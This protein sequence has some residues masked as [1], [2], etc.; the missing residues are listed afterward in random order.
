MSRTHS[1]PH[2]LIWYFTGVKGTKS[3][4]ESR[5]L[6]RREKDKQ[7]GGRKID[8]EKKL[9]NPMQH[10]ADVSVVLLHQH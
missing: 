2:Q 7:R 6:R 5:S 9:V 10:T 3:E 4:F 1:A 8:R